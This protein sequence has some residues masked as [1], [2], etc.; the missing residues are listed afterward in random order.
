MYAP[1]A[2]VVYCHCDDCQK[3]DF[4]VKNAQG[5]LVGTTKRRGKGFLQNALS[6]KDIFEVDFNPDMPWNHRVLL[7]STAVFIDFRMFNQGPPQ[8]NRH[9]RHHGGGI[10]AGLL[11]SHDVEIGY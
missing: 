5:T 2:F 4:E 8:Q 11:V 1:P 9:N 10:G 3:V 6:D 7:L